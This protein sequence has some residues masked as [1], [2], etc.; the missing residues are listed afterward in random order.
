MACPIDLSFRLEAA[1]DLC[2][3]YSTLDPALDRG[4]VFNLCAATAASEFGFEGVKR[5]DLKR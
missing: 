1:V 2:P 4:K 5:I 3:P